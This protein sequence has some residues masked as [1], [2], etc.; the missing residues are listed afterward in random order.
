[1]TSGSPIRI[2]DLS[3]S[4]R[5]LPS[6]WAVLVGLAWATAAASCTTEGTGVQHRGQL[7]VRVELVD[8]NVPPDYRDLS[9]PGL[10]A[11]IGDLE[12]AWT[13]SVQVV[14]DFGQPDGSFNGYV[15]VEVEPGSVARVEGTGAKGRNLQLVNGFGQGT[16]FVTGVFGPA[17]LWV[18]DIGYV[19][20]M[21]GQVAV[22][23]NGVDDDDDVMVDHPNDPGCA[24]ADDMTEEP[25]TNMSG[26][27][28]PVRYQLPAIADV[29]GRGAKTPYEAV[30]MQIE[31]AA[32]R[33]VVVTRVSSNGFFLT[34]LSEPY[35]PVDGTGG[36]NHLFAYNFNTPEGMQV[37]DQVTYLSG[38][39]S[40]F[41]GFTEISFPSFE[42]NYI[43]A[44]GL[45]FGPDDCL[46][47]EPTV[48]DGTDIRLSDP[49][50]MEKLESGLV[51]IEGF[52]ISDFFGPELA[53]NN[54]FGP[55][56]S[57][58]DL[59]EDG[60]IDYLDPLEGSCS[61]A[62]TEEPRCS[63]WTNYVSWGAYKVYSGIN[64]IRVST[65]TAFG[66]DALA[67]KGEPLPVL[68]GTLRN[69]SGGDLNWTIETRCVDDLICDFADCPPPPK[70]D[71]AEP[72]DPA[73]YCELCTGCLA[74]HGVPCEQ[75]CTEEP[76]GYR[77]PVRT[78]ISSRCACVSRRTEVDN[79]AYR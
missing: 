73:R 31:T 76:C 35:N 38:T 6:R 57:N 56:K 29:Q 37:C 55:N 19:P 15:R 34:D 79:D 48:L 44:A 2:D 18:E 62:C 66:F 20:A 75:D 28:S 59:N 32:P 9:G 11:N 22:C 24:F 64:M 52:T 13:F 4:G 23:A 33:N 77:C 7:D 68:S 40:E 17:R 14:D 45:P 3:R 43:N 27:S 51:R 42:V 41:F 61:D 65:A 69:F 58:C 49:V 16:A 50:G 5:P 71:E 72:D 78:P 21:D 25:G 74:D 8:G 26:V 54:S 70:F 53:V 30:S 46:V 1:M 36:Y 47:P 39:A 63:E 12:E 67:H 10:P 60:V